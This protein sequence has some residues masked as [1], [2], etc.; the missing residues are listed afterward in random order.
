[1]FTG[2]DALF[3]SIDPGVIGDSGCDLIAGIRDPATGPLVLGRVVRLP[4][5]MN[6]VATD[7]KAGEAA[8]AAV[9][10]REDLQL[11]EKTGWSAENGDPPQGIPTQFQAILS[12][13]L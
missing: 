2:R 9:L 3:L 6:F 4:R 7:E 10:T 12:S 8:Y 11:I 1:M 5:I 13:R